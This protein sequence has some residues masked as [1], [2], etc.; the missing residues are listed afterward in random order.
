MNSDGEET[1]LREKPLRA[2]AEGAGDMV[3]ARSTTKVRAGGTVKPGR[4]LKRIQRGTPTYL[5]LRR[6]ALGTLPYCY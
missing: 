2:G 4:G 3:G 1:R 5:L 6:R